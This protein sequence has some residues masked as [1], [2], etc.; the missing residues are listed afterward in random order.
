MFSYGKTP[1]PGLT[2]AEA[3]ESVLA[4]KLLGRPENC[5]DAIY[6][7]MLACWSRDAD[8]RP[9]FTAIYQTLDGFYRKSSPVPLRAMDSP[10][11]R[12]QYEFTGTGSQY[13]VVKKKGKEEEQEILY[14]L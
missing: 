10:T 7:L 4:G 9:D 3:A 6:Q 8:K 13:E 11:L 5:P 12:A 14:H 1:Y 2:N